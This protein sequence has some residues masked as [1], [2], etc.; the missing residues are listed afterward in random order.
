MMNID[1]KSGHHAIFIP[2]KRPLVRWLVLILLGLGLL[3]RVANLDQRIYWVDEVATSIRVAGYTREEVTQ[4]LA[5]GEVW[6][7]A[8]IQHYQQLTSERGWADT[9]DALRQSPEHAPLYFILARLWVQLFG[10]SVVAIRSLSVIC[11]LMALPCFYWLA[12]ELFKSPLVGWMAIGLLS[13]SPFFVAYAQEARPY[14]LWS[15][16]VLLSGIALLQAL[17]LNTRTRWGLY[18]LTLTLTLYTSLLSVFVAL[19]QGLYV[20]GMAWSASSFQSKGLMRRYWAAT[21]VAI[22]AFSPWLMVIAHHW[23][24]LQDNTTWARSPLN[25]LAMVAIWLYSLAVIVFDVSVSVDLSIE[26]VAKGIMA[27]VVLGIMGYAVYWLWMTASRRTGL[28]VILLIISTPAALISLDLIRG[29]QASATP[30]YLIPC[31]LGMLLSVAYFLSDRLTSFSRQRMILGI[32]GLWVTLSLWSCVGNLN[33]TPDYQK[34][35]NQANP[36]IAAILNQA[37]ASILIAEPEYAMDVVSLSYAL[38]S[39][40]RIQIVSADNAVF[41]QGHEY[42]YDNS[43][44]ILNPSDALRRRIERGDRFD[45]EKVYQ[46]ELLTPDDVHLSLWKLQLDSNPESR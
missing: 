1:P 42:K 24:M 25:P 32:T 36:A 34:A 4:T 3:F 33:R 20:A 27:S 31:Q 38:N 28:F 37:P 10:S 23:T 26:T 43:V 8:P 14:S 18:A 2:I 19:G 41:E 16:T 12:V 39:D 13:V 22:L 29:G 46:P 9:L 15:V 5:N 45:V 7:I 40:L 35:R 11:S 6:A 44:F 30:R 21:G 17:R